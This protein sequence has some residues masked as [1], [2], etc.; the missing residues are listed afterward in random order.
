MHFFSI[1]IYFGAI[2]C[3]TSAIK[4]VQNDVIITT[5]N[6]GTIVGRTKSTVGNL[7]KPPKTF[8]NFRNIPFAQS[9]TGD[10][11]FSVRTS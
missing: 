6:L 4:T 11:R 3:S 7:G 8:F 9:V 1:V 2:F 5:P 10:Q